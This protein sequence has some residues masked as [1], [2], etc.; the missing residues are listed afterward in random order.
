MT[1]EVHLFRI[2]TTSA[3]LRLDAHGRTALENGLR[4]VIDG[5]GGSYAHTEYATLVTARARAA[6]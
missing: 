4:S 6:S 1:A 3:Y 5:A 2:R